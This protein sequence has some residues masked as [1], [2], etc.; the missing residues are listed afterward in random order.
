MKQVKLTEI[1]KIVM[2]TLKKV[3]EDSSKNDD[4]FLNSNYSDS[5]ML[6]SIAFVTLV[7]EL[8]EIFD[9]SIDDEYLQ[10]KNLSTF[11]AITNMVKTLIELKCGSNTQQ[12]DNENF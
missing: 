9:I 5:G 12:V 6:D 2:E 10:L 11:N 7:V 8:E 3:V 4:D 1:E